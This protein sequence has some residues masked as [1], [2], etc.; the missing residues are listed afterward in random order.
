MHEVQI[1]SRTGSFAHRHI[2][3]ET[4]RSRHQK[5]MDDR[6]IGTKVKK[7]QIRQLAKGQLYHKLD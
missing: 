2:N 3:G 4:K 6:N 7:S 5:N 1:V